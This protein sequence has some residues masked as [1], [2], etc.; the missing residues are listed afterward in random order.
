[1]SFVLINLL[2]LISKREVLFRQLVENNDSIITELRTALAGI[3][4]T[5]LNTSMFID[6]LSCGT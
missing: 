3:I 6:T 5:Y 4:A 2:V 1:M